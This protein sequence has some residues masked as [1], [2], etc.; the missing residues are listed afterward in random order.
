[1]IRYAFLVSSAVALY[2]A[3]GCGGDDEGTGLG[4]GDGDIDLGDGDGNSGDGDGSI[5]GC[6]QFS[7]E[8]CSG[9][10][11][12]G[13]NVPLDIYIMYDLSCSMSCTVDQSGCCKG[14]NNEAPESDWRI[15]PVRRAMR[16]FLEDPSS[17]GIGVGLG[18]FGD[19]PVNENT[20]PQVC[21][22]EAHTDP[23]VPIGVLPGAA[24]DLIAAVNAGEPQG[25][26]PTHLGL[27]G[28]CV[29]ANQWK[30]QNPAN[31]VVILLVTDGIPEHSCGANI[32]LAVDAAEECYNSGSGREIYVL[33]VVANNNN[34]LGQLHDIAEAGGTEQAYL[35]DANNVEASMLA[36]LNAIRADAAI[37]CTLNI[38]QPPSGEMINYEKVNVG[39][40]DAS[41][42]TVTTFK[43]PAPADCAHGGW[44]YEQVG[45]EQVVQ[46]CDQ[47]CNTVSVSGAALTLSVGCDTVEVTR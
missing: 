23:E 24:A 2:A 8:G 10:T 44:Y 38:P 27:E 42:S 14:S 32:G 46:L 36:A 30:Q 33:G 12:E 31:K 5:D 15:A 45:N 13:E 18:F 37:P 6:A 21:T 1:M 35:T 9:I 29:Y 11:Y 25:G 47:T 26:T 7:S 20:N 39:V 34:S 16:A 28:A 22:V 41:R 19:H 43:V 3:V 4:D 17:A 40:C